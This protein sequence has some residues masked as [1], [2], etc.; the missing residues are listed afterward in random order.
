VTVSTD[1]AIPA[2]LNLLDR[3]LH[4]RESTIGNIKSDCEKKIVWHG[5]KKEKTPWAIVY[6]HGFSA[7]RKETWPLCD[8]L[9]ARLGANLFYTRLSGHGQDGP[10]M[11]EATVKD[12]IYDGLEAVTIGSRIGDRVILVG[13][14]TGGTLVTWLAAH[15]S[16]APLIHRLILLSPNFFPKNPLALAALWPPTLRLFEKVFGSWRSFTVINHLHAHYWTARY[17]VKA[18]ATMMQMV[19]LAWQ[20]DLK[21]AC[22]PVLMMVNPWDRVINVTLA[23]LRFRRFSS[24]GKKVVFF[25]GNKDLGRHVLAGEILS[26]TTTEKVLAVI[27]DFLGNK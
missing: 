14:S 11:G 1:K 18:I 4:G 17:P 7:S 15:H 26:R 8:R 19:R 12:W 13:T 16:T 27:L 6:L 24:P 2:H 25:R 9:A 3:Y 21:R 22:M 20:I 23:L 10:A 5:G